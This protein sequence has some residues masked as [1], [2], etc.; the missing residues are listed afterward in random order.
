MRNNMLRAPLIKS[1]VLLAAF[2]LIIYL[3]VS[4]PEG[5]LWSSIG[6]IFYT[7]FKAAQLAV[8]LILALFV[9]FAVLMGIFFGCIAMISRESAVKMYDQLRQFVQD[10]FNAVQ[11]LT[12]MGGRQEAQDSSDDSFPRLD[13][14]PTQINISLE[15]VR[16]SQRALEEKVFA[17][18]SRI[19]QT[20]QDESITKLSDWLRAE[21]EKTQDVQASLDL[22]DQQIQQL[23]KQTEDMLEKLESISS[24]F[25]S[26][27]VTGRIE[28]LEKNNNDC[29]AG[30]SSLQEKIDSLYRE[31]NDLRK[32]LSRALKE[33]GEISPA[34]DDEVEHRLFS[35]IEN[36]QDK[37]KI[38]RLVAETL[39]QDM[40]YAQ[41]T[42]HVSANVSPK[43]AGILAEHP[44][45]TTD[46]IRE[47]RKK[48]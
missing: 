13:K 37:E 5:S 47:Y 1:A 26:K 23:K 33:K 10:K 20:E 19:E 46:Y 2:S 45:L 14:I 36:S 4:S 16:K 18:Q 6:A 21:E 31:M 42:E 8:G 41:V 30:V 15:N 43:T 39:D 38:V 9:C 24:E 32:S 27:Q 40:T 3:T 11:S 29:F 17:L 25:S 7:V 22:V 28:T 44:T 48:N 12:R 35:Y 34:Q